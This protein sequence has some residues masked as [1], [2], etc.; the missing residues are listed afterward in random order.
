M[1]DHVGNQ[2]IGFLM[3]CHFYSRKSSS[4]LHSH[5]IMTYLE[6]FQEFDRQAA[7][8]VQHLFDEID[9]VLF[10]KQ[11]NQ[12]EYIKTECQ[13]WGSQFPHLR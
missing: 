2:N 4:T 5:V 11:S 7:K 3:T 10:E 12:A 6:M 13:E 8:K 9:S 1:L